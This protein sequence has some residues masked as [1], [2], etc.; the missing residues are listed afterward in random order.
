MT[1]ADSDKAILQNHIAA[2]DGWIS[3][4]RSDAVNDAVGAVE[5]VFNEQ[6]PEIRRIRWFSI[7]S[8]VELLNLWTR[9]IETDD[10]NKERKE[11][12]FDFYVN[13][14]AYMQLMAPIASAHADSFYAHVAHSLTWTQRAG[15]VPDIVRENSTTKEN[16]VKM[17]KDNP[18][19][20]FLILLSLIPPRV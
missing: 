16:T 17:L 1:Y 12:V 15:V 9:F 7:A 11:S 20:L 8:P 5:M 3:L 13:G 4:Y 18:W 14:T 6:I 2:V 10:A 19:A